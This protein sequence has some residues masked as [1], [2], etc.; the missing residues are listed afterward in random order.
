MPKQR[1]G[2]TPRA[3]CMLA[4]LSMWMVVF[5]LF[6]APLW[7]LPASFDIGVAKLVPILTIILALLGVR[8]LASW[9]TRTVDLR[10]PWVFAGI[11]LFLVA[12]F[13]SLAAAANDAFV[14]GSLLLVGLFTLFGLAISQ[15]AKSQTA[16][17]R[18]LGAMLAAGC[19]A[20]LVAIAQYAGLLGDPTLHPVARV[21]STLGNRNYLGSLLGVISLP[22]LA[23]LHGTRK[24]VTRVAVW[25]GVALCFFGV[26]LVQQTGILLAIGAGFLFVVVGIVVLRLGSYVRRHVRPIVMLVLA[27]VIGLGFGLTLWRL[28]PYGSQ[29]P[30]TGSLVERLWDANSG[31]TREVDW[32]VAWEMFVRNP[33]TGVG[34]GNYKVD[35]LEYKSSFLSSAQGVGYTSPVKRATHA[36][37]DYLQTIAE[38]GIPGLLALVV[39]VGLLTWSSW[40]RCRS[41]QGAKQ[42][43]LLLLLGGLVVG[44]AHAVVSFPLHLP[45]TALVLVVLLGLAS[46]VHFGD[47]ATIQVK[48]SRD[49]A[50]WG[51]VLVLILVVSIGCLLVR[52]LS[53]QLYVSRGVRQ[54]EAGDS[55]QAQALL[56]QGIARSAFHA[57][58]K[59]RLASVA[60]WRSDRARQSG[61]GT[62]A[63]DLLLTAWSNALASQREYP[64]EPG[65]LL[66]AGIATMRGDDAFA[67]QVIGTLLESRPLAGYER[68]A[69]YLLAT[70]DAQ[71]G[72]AGA[73]MEA[74]QQLTID[75]PDY[76][77]AFILL[78]RLALQEGDVPHALEILDQGKAAAQAALAQVTAELSTAGDLKRSSLEFDQQRLMLELQTLESLRENR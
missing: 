5:V 66:L 34:L 12:G 28:D 49:A 27:M 68:D 58:A 48:V 75:F 13:L 47:Q 8:A 76:V 22:A 37:N 15:M 53:A 36:H 14:L 78:A 72:E 16:L 20:T 44:G 17:Q 54:M 30:S 40:V 9:I 51:T 26:S 2:T 45:A 42:L 43:R 62:Q 65:L 1:S 3:Q 73:A 46:S 31:E 11:A 18:I 67:R 23:L 29:P 7:V 19:L 61:N 57:E 71:Q 35:F 77:Q 64:T 55:A 63:D 70:L 24:K 59:Y 60:L 21:T 52:E 33:G 6:A 74:L 41:V 32:A 56:E 25:S 4:R 50:R 69:R 38:L 10:I 39:M